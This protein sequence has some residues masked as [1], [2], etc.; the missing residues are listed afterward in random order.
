MHCL[1]LLHQ[2]CCTSLPPNLVP[3]PHQANPPRGETTRQ[4]HARPP[5]SCSIC[6]RARQTPAS[7]LVPTRRYTFCIS[8][9]LGTATPASVATRIDLL[10]APNTTSTLALSQITLTPTW[11][12]YC[13]AGYRPVVATSGFFTIYLAFASATYDFDDV[14]LTSVDAGPEPEG[15]YAPAKVNALLSTFEAINIPFTNRFVLHNQPAIRNMATDGNFSVGVID[16]AGAG[17]VSHAVRR[18]GTCAGGLLACLLLLVGWGLGGLQRVIDLA[19]R[20]RRG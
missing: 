4:Q 15:F 13:L 1:A 10:Y 17:S 5:A 6:H 7:S 14:S 20:Q 11:A 16:L 12:R 19:G 8:A 18:Y 3:L 2:P 9:R